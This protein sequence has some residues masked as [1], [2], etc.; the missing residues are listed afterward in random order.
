VAGQGFVCRD[1]D[2]K[3]DEAAAL[4]M[5]GQKDPSPELHSEGICLLL[6]K[7]LT[8][9]CHSL[10]TN[11]HLIH[12]HECLLKMLWQSDTRKVIEGDPYLSQ[13]FRKASRT[14]RTK[15]AQSSLVR[16]ATI[17]VALEVLA[18]NLVSWGDYFPAL[19]EETER[20]LL[21]DPP[22]GERFWLTDEYLGH[23]PS[24]F[25]RRRLF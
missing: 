9:Q 25:Q 19:R 21:G 11:F 17:I 13:M 15:Q 8:D 16:V 4:K 23:S 2:T 5:N 10:I 22:I 12:G 7:E 24:I 20:K 6:P 14:R 18:R 1:H 3:I